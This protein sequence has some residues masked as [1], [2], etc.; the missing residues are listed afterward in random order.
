MAF[1]FGTP[2]PAPAAGGGF[3]FGGTANPAPA[4]GGFGF[5]SLA[6]APSAK[7]SLFG[8]A[9]APAGGLFGSSTP[10]SAPS[11]FG[12]FGPAP[13]SG[14][15]LFGTPAPSSFGA[16]S[17]PFGSAPP[18]GSV[19]FGSAAPAS[20]GA[21]QAAAPMVPA[22]P[23]ISSLTTY[24]DLPPQTKQAIDGI[25]EQML[26]HRRT[27]M[28]VETMGP[29]LLRDVKPGD[30]AGGTMFPLKGQLFDLERNLD[31]LN[32]KIQKC[33]REAM[34][35]KA[36]FEQSTL[37]S[38]TYGVWPIEAL[39]ARRGVQLSTVETAATD[40]TVQEELRK[41]LDMQTAYVDRIEKIPSPFMWLQLADME[42]RLT[43]LTHMIQ[44]LEQQLEMTKIVNNNGVAS[45]VQQQTEFLRRMDYA[46]ARVHGSMEGLRKRYRLWERGPNILDKAIAEEESHRRRNSEQVKIAYLKGLQA[47]QNSGPPSGAPATGDLF[48]SK[49]SAGGLFGSTPVPVPGVGGLFGSTPAPAGASLFGSAPAP[50]GGGLFGSTPAPAPAGGGLFG[51]APAPTPAGGGGLFGSAPAPAPAGGNLFGATAASAFGAPDAGAFGSFASSVTSTPKAKKTSSSSSRRRK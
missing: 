35:L 1:S 40:R 23:G 43:E 21:P 7:P 18:T 20:F 33:G 28:Q 47:P 46:V 42:H 32:D 10:A 24:S 30:A 12:G 5:G 37:Q 39:A 4:P 19:G 11:G 38:V 45:V 41:Q 49:P 17:P 26:R 14:A 48:G 50:V 44:S 3:S 22:A 36:K 13:A 16:A 8:S 27:M 2:A 6:P 15:S 25:H 29:A 34:V 31:A 9:P 51:S